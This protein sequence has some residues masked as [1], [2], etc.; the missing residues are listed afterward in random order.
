M[1]L[2]NGSLHDLYEFR[3]EWE[4]LDW[5]ISVL[6]TLEIAGVRGLRKTWE[7]KPL[8]TSMDLKKFEDSHFL[9]RH[10]GEYVRLGDA[11]RLSLIHI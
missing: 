10:S 6:A 4:Y 11:I 2:L 1:S 8:N 5:W 7:G 9:D 3:H